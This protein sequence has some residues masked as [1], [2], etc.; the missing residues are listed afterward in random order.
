MT[1]N[2]GTR[3][4]CFPGVTGLDSFLA[5]EMRSSQP[6]KAGF[7]EH[8]SAKMD[9]FLTSLPIRRSSGVRTCLTRI[10]TLAVSPLHAP[11]RLGR[12]VHR[13]DS[14]GLRARLDKLDN[15]GGLWYRY[16]WIAN[17]TTASWR[18]AA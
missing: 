8:L 5:A 2:L 18:C 6:S 3:P 15:R 17:V 1:P 13:T 16:V 11:R 10:A 12:R 14:Q 9:Y 4:I 7:G